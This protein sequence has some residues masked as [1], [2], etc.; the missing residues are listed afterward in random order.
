MRVLPRLRMFG[1]LLCGV[2]GF[3]CNGSSPAVVGAGDGGVP[4]AGTD[5]RPTGTGNTDTSST[6]TTKQDSGGGGK[7]PGTADARIN[8]DLPPV[9]VNTAAKRIVPGRARLV[10]GGL[11]S[12][13][14]Q[15]PASGNGDRWCAYSQPGASLGA[16][17]LWV[18]NLTKAV[19]GDVKCDG[20]SL[21]CRKL[22]SDL[23]TGTPQDG[24]VYPFSDR[25][26]GDT[27]IFH[28]DT[29][30]GQSDLYDGP[31]YAWRPGWQK[32]RV[33]SSKHG[34]TCSGHART[35]VA[36][37]IDNISAPD[38]TPV[39]FDILAGRLADS[40]T[41]QLPKVARP[42]PV[43]SNQASQW[44][45]NFNRAGDYFAYSTGGATISER[46][47]LFVMKTEDTGNP[48]KYTKVGDGIS[49]WQISADG[50]R[51]YY[52][53]NYNYSVEGDPAGTFTMADF[54]GGANETTLA[55]KVGAYILLND[56]TDVDR[57]I[58][59]FVN[60]AVG[61][62]ALKL[63]KDT[64]KKDELITVASNIASASMS[65]DLRYTM[66]AKEFDSVDDTSDAYIAKNDG[67]GSCTLTSALTTDSSFG[68]TFN[69][70]AGLTF[71]AD[72]VDVSLGLGEGWLAN[73]DG[74]SGKKKFATNVDFWF[75]V[76]DQGLIYTDEG[77]G[78]VAR[79]RFAQTPD[80]KEWPAGGGTTVQEQV[81]RIFSLTLP[82]Y[83]TAVFTMGGDVNRVGIYAFSAFPFA[84]AQAAKDGGAGDTAPA[85][86]T[87]AAAKD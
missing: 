73:P 17:E 46:E 13:S 66:F 31:V 25:F 19:A 23:W 11:S 52:Y 26:D 29:K 28:A 12:C 72:K 84:A 61:K 75:A 34:I 71:W 60:V 38:V 16:T 74:C 1:L 65:R 18:I 48:D 53:R 40:D 86:S 78:D 54:P 33:I 69:T 8:P 30:S 85:A 42:T 63:L 81:G 3:A 7:T 2:G 6:T 35:D 59:L 5:G 22:S 32:P 4:A 37:C 10:G 64:N 44:R 83:D 47:A 27:L 79:L 49:R 76:G 77:D 68:A 87:D 24:P 67:S 36:W 15:V 82:N 41:S 39:R 70:S 20:S 80:G 56:G 45:G 21:D 14:N 51:W 58:G 55:G 50:K 62:G 9:S 57:G 43:R